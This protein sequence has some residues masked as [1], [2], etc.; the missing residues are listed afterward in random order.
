MV[1]SYEVMKD[2]GFHYID[3][4]TDSGFTPCCVVQGAVTRHQHWFMEL[5]ACFASGPTSMR[6]TAASNGLTSN[7]TKWPVLDL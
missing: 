2:S 4:I 1:L 5:T 6:F 3:Y 7:A